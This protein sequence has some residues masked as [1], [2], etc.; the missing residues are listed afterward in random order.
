MA[1]MGKDT[2]LDTSLH[3]GPSLDIHLR[4]AFAEASAVI[5]AITIT[6]AHYPCKTVGLKV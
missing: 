5:V 2:C 3:M 1:E 4:K 6:E